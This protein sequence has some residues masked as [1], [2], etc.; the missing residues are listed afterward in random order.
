[1]KDFTYYAPTRVVFGKGVENKIGEHLKARGYAKVLIHFGGGSIRSTGVLERVERSLDSAGIKWLELGGVEPNPKI[2]LVREGIAFAKQEKID[3]ILA[4]GG[5][6][7]IDSAKSIA[8]G[9]ANGVDPWKLIVDKM[10]PKTCFPLGVVLTIAA[11]GSEM[12]SSHVISNPDLH[13][14]R[15]L[16]SDLV[17]PEIA[18]ENPELTYSV[19]PYQ[20]AC[21]IVDTMMHTLERYY[22]ADTDTELT[23]RI[24]EGLLV[25]VKNA[26]LAAMANP[27]DYEAR[28]TLMWASSLSHN[29]LTGC[30]KLAPFPAHKI[31]HDVSGLHDSVSHGA[32]LAVLFPA[33]ARFVYHLDVRKF[34]QGAVRIWGV[35]M[36]HD[37]PERTALKG[38][39]AMQAY[40]SALGMPRTVSELG[41]DSS[42]YRHLAEMSTNG[43]SSPL[44]SYIPLGVDE[45]T[46]IYHL[47]E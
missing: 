24:A 42:E 46:A 37:H 26:G 36:D 12:S 10:I 31:E 5:G 17:R 29:G 11:A 18:F 21:G 4:I 30:G 34:A 32:G 7:V 6:S 38:I 2:G 47:A 39:E 28:A 14:K 40:F 9:L 45:I 33:W 19:S 15:S 13:L 22:T 25:S 27:Q 23:D 3:F 16:N 35:D 1:M 20:T 43:G 44:K 41:V 8:L